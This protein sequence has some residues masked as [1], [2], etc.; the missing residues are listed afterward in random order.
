MQYLKSICA[1]SRCHLP[2]AS[3]MLLLIGDGCGRCVETACE[4]HSP[5][6]K[7]VSHKSEAG[8]ADTM[9]W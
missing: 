3:G 1:T 5:V 7:A 9:W 6:P 8:G 4:Q 2:A